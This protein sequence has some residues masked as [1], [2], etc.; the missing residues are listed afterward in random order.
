MSYLKP[1]GRRIHV[2][3]ERASTVI[4]TSE[5]NLIERAEVIAVGK[6]VREI[7]PGDRVL[8]TSFGVDSIDIDGVRNYFLLEDDAFI[9]AV[10]VE[11]EP[12]QGPMASQ[13]SVR[14]MLAGDPRGDMP[15]LSRAPLL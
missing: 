1:F 2:R 4:Q 6:L 10:D 15:N 7:M 5:A 11:G 9:L 14:E 8:F 13:V 3:P 12:M